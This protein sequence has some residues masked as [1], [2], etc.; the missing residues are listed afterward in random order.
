MDDAPQP[1]CMRPLYLLQRVRAGL[2]AVDD[3]RKLQFLC[4]L[5]LPSEPVFLN[6]VVLLI[7]VIIKAG[8]TH[9]HSLRILALLL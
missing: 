9:R 3:N 7:P 4:K 8:L 2:P 5:K 6:L 1:L